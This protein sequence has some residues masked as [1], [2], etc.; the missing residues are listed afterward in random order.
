[1][2]AESPATEVLTVSEDGPVR[3]VRLNRGAS[4]LSNGQRPASATD[5]LHLALMTSRGCIVVR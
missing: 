5:Q 4:G 2:S 3:I 1:M